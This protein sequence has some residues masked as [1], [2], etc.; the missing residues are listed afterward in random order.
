MIPLLL[1]LSKKR[2]LKIALS[3][4]KLWGKELKN[5]NRDFAAIKKQH[6][7]IS[8]EKIVQFVIDDQSWHDLNIDEIYKKI[9]RTFT[10]PGEN[11]LYHILQRPLFESKEVESRN[12]IINTLT[13]RKDFREKIQYELLNLYRD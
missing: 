12:K 10:T 8:K 9:D 13:D 4:K 6:Q 2:E 3:I 5:K 11:I 1:L 7:T